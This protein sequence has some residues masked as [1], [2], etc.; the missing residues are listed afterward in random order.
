VRWFEPEIEYELPHTYMDD[1]LEHLKGR[2]KMSDLQVELTRQNKQAEDIGL[3]FL[4]I[5]QDHRASTGESLLAHNYDDV[6]SAYP[7][8][9]DR[10][11]SPMWSL[12]WKKCCRP[13]YFKHWNSA[14]SSL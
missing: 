7:F 3:S 10:N 9:A 2:V 12:R 6:R 8:L 5:Y 11:P 1:I 14:G 13:C 4:L